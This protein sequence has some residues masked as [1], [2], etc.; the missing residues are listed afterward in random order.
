[1]SYTNRQKQ[2]DYQN[3]WLKNRRLKWLQENGPCAECGSWEK[4]EVDHI[5]PETKI[6]HKVWSWSQ[7]RRDIELAKCQVLCNYCHLRKS[8]PERNSAPASHGT[9]Y[10][11]DKFKCRCISCTKA[12]NT[13]R[14][15]SRTNK[16]L[17]DAGVL[18]IAIQL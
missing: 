9:Q 15:I 10:Y 4:L 8:L 14:Q 13:R 7:E 17:K 18:G 11:Y 12:S 5:N 2:R 1:M 6:D 3:T 16:K